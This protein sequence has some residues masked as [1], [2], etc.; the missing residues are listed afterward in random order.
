MESSC[1]SVLLGVAV[2][3]CGSALAQ[4]MPSRV[5]LAAIRADE[6]Q[7][8]KREKLPE[9]IR[10][11]Q[12]GPGSMVGDLGTGYG[13]YAARFS[14]VVRPKGAFSRERS[15]PRCSTKFASSYKRTTLKTSPSCSALLPIP[16][17]QLLLS[18]L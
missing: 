10:A 9:I 16:S 4:P 8:D 2:I 5:S 6:Q 1:P 3:L 11:V 18:T 12:L 7:R 17:F 14:P 15:T 13:Y